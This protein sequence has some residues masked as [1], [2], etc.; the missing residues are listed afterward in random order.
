MF[1]LFFIFQELTLKPV[2]PSKPEASHVYP[3]PCAGDLGDQKLPI[4][5]QHKR[6]RNRRG[7]NQREKELI[8]DFCSSSCLEWEDPRR[9]VCEQ[10]PTKE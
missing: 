5:L 9:Q 7:E 3:N 6:Q 1:F 8:V 10:R 2:D 4:E